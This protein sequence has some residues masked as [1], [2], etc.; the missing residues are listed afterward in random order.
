MDVQGP[1]SNATPGTGMNGRGKTP[2]RQETRGVVV[3][4]K[5]D[6]GI[7]STTWSRRGDGP[8]GRC[9]APPRAS[10]ANSPPRI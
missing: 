5:L 9:S 8:K 2:V 6:V 4:D 3:N 10:R 7:K 1:E